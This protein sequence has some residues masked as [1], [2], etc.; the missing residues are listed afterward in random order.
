MYRPSKYK[1]GDLI[2]RWVFYGDAPEIDEIPYMSRLYLV[3]GT[4]NK[5]Y[6]LLTEAGKVIHKECWYVDN[7]KFI[8][9]T[10]DGSWLTGWGRVDYGKRL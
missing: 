6:L 10:V 8:I 5:N 9:P 2:E 3:L 7:P 1:R 4:K